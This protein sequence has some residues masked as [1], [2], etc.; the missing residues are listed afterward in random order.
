[1]VVALN[2]GGIT[3]PVGVLLFLTSGL[4]NVSLMAAS[5]HILPII[6]IFVAVIA[7][8]ALV[9]EVVTFLP[10]LFIR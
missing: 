4:A 2:L 1:M 10:S 8:I 9:P 6:P 3:P 7:L 5:R